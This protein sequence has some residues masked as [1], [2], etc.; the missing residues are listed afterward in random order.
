M[1]G[2]ESVSELLD[3]DLVDLKAYIN[4]ADFECKCPTDGTRARWPEE[5]EAGIMKAPV[6]TTLT[7]TNGSTAA[8][9]YAF[10]TAYFGSFVQIGDKF[11][12]YNGV[13]S[14][15][16]PWDGDSGDY[17][18][19]VYHNAKTL[20]WYVI[21][22]AGMPSLIGIGVLSPLPGPDAEL[23]IRSEPA[24]DF[25]SRGASAPFAVSRNLFRQSNFFNVGDPRYYYIDQASVG[26]TFTL[27]NRFHVYPIPERAVTFEVRANVV[28]NSL[29]ADADVPN[30][31]AQAVDN[32]LLP[33][34]REILALNST[35]RRYTGPNVAQLTLLADRARNQLRALSRV[36]Q[37]SAQSIRVRRNW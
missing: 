6:A 31:P 20:P 11:Y 34:A 17:A 28:P 4:Q 33:I 1:W 21:K 35:N 36:Q 18:A 22:L 10:E 30:M 15:L 29:T 3:Q 2:A 24:F 8:T 12:R 19:T 9:G 27:G 7:L 26:A 13:A 5:Y 16:E 37:N 14:L 32:I 25:D 23:T